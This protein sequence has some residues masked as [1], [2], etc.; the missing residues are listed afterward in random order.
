MSGMYLLRVCM[1]TCLYNNALIMSQNQFLDYETAKEG[2][3]T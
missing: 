2:D 3:P 1:Q